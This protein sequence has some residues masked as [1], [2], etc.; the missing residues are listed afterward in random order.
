MNDA[1]ASALQQFQNIPIADLGKALAEAVQD[2][3]QVIQ[4]LE[5]DLSTALEAWVPV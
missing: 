4:N 1:L 2:A 3:G 5:N